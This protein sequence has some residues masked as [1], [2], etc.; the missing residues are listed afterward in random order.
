MV[1]E[2]SLQS[3]FVC[4]CRWVPRSPG[5]KQVQI[6]SRLHCGYPLSCFEERTEDIPELTDTVM[7]H[8]LDSRKVAGSTH[9]SLSVNKGMST[10]V[11]WGSP[12]TQNVRAVGQMHTSQH[13]VLHV[14]WNTL[15]CGSV[16]MTYSG[17]EA[18]GQNILDMEP[19]AKSLG[20]IA[21]WR[22]VPLS[23]SPTNMRLSKSKIRS[24]KKKKKGERKCYGQLYSNL[25]EN[26]N[27]VDAFVWENLNY[28][29][30]VKK[31][32]FKSINLKNVYMKK[33]QI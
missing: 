1:H 4:T 5:D 10:S 28:K 29:N 14:P 22:T 17:K 31:K 8:C 16:G 13:L 12:W 18:R 26:L 24:Q 6:H 7:P 30:Y 11:S 9:I 25:F 21:K 23:L 2:A 15:S 3:T 32:N 27:E 19:R 20:Q 33:L